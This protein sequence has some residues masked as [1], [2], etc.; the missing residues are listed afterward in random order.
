MVVD[1]RAKLALWEDIVGER[2]K[3]VFVSHSSTI[4]LVQIQ[5]PVGIKIIASYLRQSLYNELVKKNLIFY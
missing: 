2:S 5:T 1:A 4:T 3:L